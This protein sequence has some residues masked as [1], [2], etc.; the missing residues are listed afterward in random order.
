MKLKITFLLAFLIVCNSTLFAQEIKIDRLEPEFWWTGFAETELQLL[1]YGEDMGDAN[2][3][4]DYPG[5]HLKKII[6]TENPNYLFVYLDITGE[7][8][9]GKVPL[10]FTRGEESVIHEYQLRERA[11][12]GNRHLGFDSS[13]V[14]Y[15][16]MPDRFAN[17]DP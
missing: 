3:S 12:S 5:V 1:V 15:L 11:G 17:G 7:A 14:I 4:L 2:V 8:I 16:L 9:P 13:D 10:Q 6:A